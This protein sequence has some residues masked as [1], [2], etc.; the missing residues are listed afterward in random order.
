MSLKIETINLDEII[1]DPT[2]ARKHSPQ[3]LRSIK[4]SLAAFGQQKP[5]VI[6]SE[7]IVIAGNGTT[8]AAKELDWA[9]IA[10]VRVPADWSAEKI[11]AYALADNKTA[12]LAEWDAEALQLQALELKDDFDL[13]E[14]GF[15]DEDLSVFTVT[16]VEPPQLADGDKNEFEQI[17]F[18]LHESQAMIIREAI[19]EAKLSD[20]IE[21]TVNDNSNA[22]AITLIAERY[23]NA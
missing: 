19:A 3:N 11:K 1:L 22:N 7:N 23:L 16:E 21:A 13:A 9:T 5:I 20:V 15:T 4:N 2:N 18:T 8:T 10:A 6:T 14:F 12:E 17:T